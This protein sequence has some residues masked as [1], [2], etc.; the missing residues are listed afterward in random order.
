MRLYTNGAEA[1]R[2]DSSG[3]LLVGTTGSP[4]LANGTTA[5]SATIKA[6]GFGFAANAPSTLVGIFNRTNTTGDIIEFKYNAAVVGQISTNGTVVTYGGTSDY[7]LKSNQTP[8]TGS[9]EFIDSLKPKTWNWVQDGS[10]GTGFIAHEFAEVSPSSVNG[11][12]DAVDAEGKPVYQAMQASSAEV[13]ANLVA[14][15]QSLRKRLAALES[16]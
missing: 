5:A 13:I 1:A 3:N 6:G 16:N 4:W 12:K 10:K 2:I 14:E 11:E 9:G 8:L 15:I 7:R